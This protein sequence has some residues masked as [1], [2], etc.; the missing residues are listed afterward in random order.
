L[1][2]RLLNE[3]SLKL[4]KGKTRL[5]ENKIC[6]TNLNCNNFGNFILIKIAYF[7]VLKIEFYVEK[8]KEKLIS[9][10]LHLKLDPCERFIVEKKCSK[11]TYQRIKLGE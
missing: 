6:E 8:T 5:K 3:T 2:F 7:S 10:L 9:I 11:I 4:Q 1:K